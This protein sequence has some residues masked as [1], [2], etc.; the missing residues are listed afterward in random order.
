M[1]TNYL[2]G[3]L[4]DQMFAAGVPYEPP[5]IYYVGVFLGDPLPDGS[6]AAEA[7]GMGAG[8][9]YQRMSIFWELIGDDYYNST[10][11][12]FP[13]LPV[14]TF[15]H[16]G[17]FDSDDLGTANLLIYGQFTTPIVIGG[18]GGPYSIPITSIRALLS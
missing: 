10:P 7:S 18:L 8:I 15:T 11:I 12:N 16:G 1:I 9:E 6:G 17:V 14:G 4:N 13:A 5:A 3:L 2:K